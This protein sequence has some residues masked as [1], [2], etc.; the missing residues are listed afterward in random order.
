MDMQITKSRENMLQKIPEIEKAL[1][2]VAFLAQPHG[3]LFNFA[4]R[5]LGV[6]F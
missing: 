4:L 1:E 2:I 3:K 6:S 5:F